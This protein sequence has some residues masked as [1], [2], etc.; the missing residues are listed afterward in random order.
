MKVSTAIKELT[1]G[2]YLSLLQET[3]TK[4]AFEK[5]KEND[6]MPSP[7]VEIFTIHL[8]LTMAGTGNLTGTT[9]AN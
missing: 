3:K 7:T 8:C 1:D 9:H 6:V 4:K 5:G 2:C